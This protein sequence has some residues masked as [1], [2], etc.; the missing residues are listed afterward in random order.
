MC[1]ECNECP[2]QKQCN[3]YAKTANPQSKS[4]VFNP[5]FQE[6]REESYQNITSEQGINERINRS[7]QAEGMFSKLKEG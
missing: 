4:I 2:Y 7:I 6:P 5:R 3:K 1:Y